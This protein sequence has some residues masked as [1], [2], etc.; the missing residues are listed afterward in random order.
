[1]K[2]TSRRSNRRRLGSRG[3]TVIELLIA[4]AMIGILAGLVLP[5]LR[6]ERSQ[7]D[8]AART[9]GMA[10]LT[11]RSDAVARGHHVLVVFDTTAGVVRTVWDL[12]N[13]RQP[14]AGEK[15][16]PFLLGERIVFGRGAGTPP[17]GDATAQVPE[18]LGGRG[19]PLLVVQRNGALDRAGV[20]Y[21]TS[22]RGRA[23]VGEIDTRAVRFD[24][25]TGRP[26][27]YVF[28]NAGWVRQ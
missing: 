7:V 9:L 2:R 18:F 16:R 1:M 17:F 27:V 5:R 23:G 4:I 10:L 20:L 19:S 21:L 25:A 11:A 3:F 28:G 24:R 22:R 26:T 13:N 14:D 15:S 12:N 6:V 8:A